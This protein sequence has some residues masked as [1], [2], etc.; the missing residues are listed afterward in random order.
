MAK[1]HGKKA[2]KAQ[3]KKKRKRMARRGA[4][5]KERQRTQEEMDAAR[6]R[7]YSEGVG[8]SLIVREKRDDKEAMKNV[9][10]MSTIKRTVHSSKSAANLFQSQMNLHP[11]E[12]T[13]ANTSEIRENRVSTQESEGEV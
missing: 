9:V 6:A 2:Q 13:S 7:A 11:K 10:D 1:K 12:S 3:A 8:D 4:A 5:K